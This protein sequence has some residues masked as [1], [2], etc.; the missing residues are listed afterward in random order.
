MIGPLM[1]ALA[2]YADEDG[3]RA[4]T[5]AGVVEAVEVRGHYDN[6]VGTSGAASQ[7]SVTASADRQPAGAAAPASCSSSCR[8]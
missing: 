4:A 3:M 7:G 8:A 2:A 6:G 1:V 5:A